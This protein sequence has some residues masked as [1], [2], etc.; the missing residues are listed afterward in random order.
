MYGEMGMII[1]ILQG[2]CPYE[3]KKINFYFSF[4]NGNGE[5]GMEIAIA[6]SMRKNPPR[7][8]F[9]GP[10]FSGRGRATIV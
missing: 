4:Q 8:T 2:W 10:P 6:K 3:L 9:F 1:A 5:M 7:H